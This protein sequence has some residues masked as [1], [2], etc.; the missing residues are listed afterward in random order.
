MKSIIK[1]SLVLGAVSCFA[2]AN[3]A[4]AAELE[5]ADNGYFKQKVV[6]HVNDLATAKAAMRNVKNHLQALGN[7]NVEIRVVTH[8][9]GSTMLVEGTK[10][11][12][13]PKGEDFSATIAS[14]S[15]DG[16]TFYICKNTIRGLKIDEKKIDLR[17]KQ[18]PSGVA[19]I[20]H[21]QQ[22]GFL[23]MKP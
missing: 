17:A 9:V 19:E 22:K 8:G 15:N 12:K 3:V 13:D 18:V 10:D 21:L 2:L 6:Y 1:T 4:G 11:P 7:K 23:Y 20:A 5:K 14:L 16:V